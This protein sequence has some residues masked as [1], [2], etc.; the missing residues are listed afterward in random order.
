A[1]RAVAPP[2]AEQAQFLLAA[3][4]EGTAPGRAPAA[5][6]RS[7]FDQF[8]PRFD[9][10]LAALG[11]ATPA[12]L[13][14]LVEA[15]GVAPARALDVLD[16]GCGTGLSGVALAPFARRLVG[17]DLSPR[18]LAEAGARGLYDT[19]AEADLLDWLPAQVAAFDLVFAADV[20]NYLGDLAPALAGIAGALR[21]GG[22]AAFS[23]ETGSV[24]PYALGEGMRYRHAPA[25]VVALAEA[26]GLRVVAMRDVVLRQE[27]AVPVAGT[28][29]LTAR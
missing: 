10:A 15:A 25:H 17:V 26:A 1:R 4:G 11:Y 19:L 12:A 18:M 21:P 5:Y 20:L 14:A 23:I 27:K 8:A 9:G 2:V 22:W 6:V 24:A 7:L 13:S 3:L 29:F 16:L 28:L